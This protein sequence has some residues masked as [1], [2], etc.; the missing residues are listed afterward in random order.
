[1]QGFLATRV[2]SVSLSRSAPR[3]EKLTLRPAQLIVTQTH[4]QL[5]FFLVCIGT[6]ISLLGSWLYVGFTVK[7]HQ[8]RLHQFIP[9]RVAEGVRTAIRRSYATELTLIDLQMWL[10]GSACVAI[11]IT[12][13]MINYV[14]KRPAGLAPADRGLRRIFRIAS[15]IAL[16]TTVAATLGGELGASR[17]LTCRLRLSIAAVLQY[18]LRRSHGGY[19]SASAFFRE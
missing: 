15:E 9:V 16:P 19:N 7:L 14:A 6:T 12:G 4:K 5:F 11:A 3:R 18:S 17:R 8:G 13:G 2:A 1:M 10:W